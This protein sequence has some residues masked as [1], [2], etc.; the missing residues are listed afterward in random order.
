MYL[1][2]TENPTMSF[3]GF[4][5][6]TNRIYLSQASRRLE[7]VPSDISDTQTLS[8]STSLSLAF[9]LMLVT[10]W[11]QDCCFTSRQEEGERPVDK[12]GM[13]VESACF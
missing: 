8:F 4:F 10:L 11:L 12:R 5:L 9:I 13:P 1:E 7:I 3:L 2:T 6:L